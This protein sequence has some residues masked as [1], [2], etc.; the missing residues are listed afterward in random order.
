MK[1]MYKI[2]LILVV[3]IV[4]PLSFSKHFF[5]EAAS[6]YDIPKNN[7][8][9]LHGVSIRPTENVAQFDSTKEIAAIKSSTQT[10]KNPTTS[11]IISAGLLPK[12]GKSYTY[13]PSF[14]G[15]E[16]KTYSAERNPYFDQ[17][18]NLLEDE[19]TG[20]TYIESANSF[21][22]GI[23]YSDVFYFSLDYPMQAKTTI[24]DTD[25]GFESDDYTDVTVISTTQTVRTKAGTFKNVV[26][27][28]YPNGSKLFI[29]KDYGI[30]KITD[31][32]GN[33]STELTAVE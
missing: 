30:I 14:Q 24:R 17:A 4:L 25:Y 31:Y 6:T 3:L 16:K 5:T 28:Q 26:V 8:T 21:S 20:Y 2:T 1:K 9:S 23:A 12:T 15:P 7:G 27:L 13:E 33:I 10:K 18:V 32:E 11:T 19:Y 22:L 29:A